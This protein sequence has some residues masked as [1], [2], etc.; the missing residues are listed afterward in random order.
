MVRYN[1]LNGAVRRIEVSVTLDFGDRGSDG[2]YYRLNPRF[3]SVQL[4]SLPL[5]YIP[6]PYDC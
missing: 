4:I 2:S 3:L 5:I 6:H 1:I